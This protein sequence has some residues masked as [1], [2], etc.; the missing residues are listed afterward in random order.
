MSYQKINL[1]HSIY[2]FSPVIFFRVTQSKN[3]FKDGHR[4]G[5]NLHIHSTIYLW[6]DTFN[7]QSLSLANL[8][9]PSQF[10]VLFFMLRKWGKYDFFLY[11]IFL[12]C[13]FY[14]VKKA[15]KEMNHFTFHI[16]SAA[17]I[18][19]SHWLYQLLQFS[20]PPEFIIHLTQ[21][22]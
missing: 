3:M 22:H 19:H 15:R 14:H 12:F 1:S 18:Q 2:N 4:E 11:L 13:P 8:L 17:T 6:A 5:I 20:P 7:S 9:W 10:F 21:L 16:S